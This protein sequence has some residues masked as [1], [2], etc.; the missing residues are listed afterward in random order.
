MRDAEQDRSSTLEAGLGAREK[1]RE[2]LKVRKEWRERDLHSALLNGCR[3]DIGGTCGGC[4]AAQYRI[5]RGWVRGGTCACP[6]A[7]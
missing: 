6:G 2:R 1:T 5:G 7:G 3:L 4:V